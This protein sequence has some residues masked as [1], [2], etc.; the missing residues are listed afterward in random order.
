MKP[1]VRTRRFRVDATKVLGPDRTIGAPSAS[2]TAP[3]E[4]ELAPSA[5]AAGEQRTGRHL[6]AAY[7]V[8]AAHR[9]FGTLAS[10]P[11]ELQLSSTR[12]LGGS[13]IARALMAATVPLVLTILGRVLT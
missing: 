6:S 2:P 9:T 11:T 13:A 3:H 12:H 8:V 7:V 4:P 10:V 5:P 1:T